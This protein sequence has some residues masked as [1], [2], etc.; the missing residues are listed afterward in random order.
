ML[1]SKLNINCKLV[2]IKTSIL[3]N[4][5]VKVHNK[6]IGTTLCCNWISYTAFTT[7]IK[8]TITVEARKQVFLSAWFNNTKFVFKTIYCHR[9]A[10]NVTTQFQCRPGSI[11]VWVFFIQPL[12]SLV[13]FYKKISPEILWRFIHSSKMF[14]LD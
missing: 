14:N 8:F 2:N 6:D 13:S 3:L 11:L 12:W 7:T 1:F 4:K 10:L 5:F 9:H